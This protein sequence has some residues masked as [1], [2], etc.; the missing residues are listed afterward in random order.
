MRVH[1]ADNLQTALDAADYSTV[2]VLDAGG[3][4]TGNYQVKPKRW[5]DGWIYI[6]SSAF[7]LQES[8]AAPPPQTRVRPEDAEQMAKL[9]SPNMQPALAITTK[10]TAAATSHVRLVGLELTSTST[11]KADP[12][13]KPWPIN[14]QCP[15]LLALQGTDSITI[16]RCYIHGSDVV[17]VTHAVIA[18]QGASNIAVV[19][20]WISD[21]HI[22]GSDSQAFC[23]TSSPGPGKLV[24]NHFSASSEDVMFGGSGVN[25]PAPFNGYVPSDLEIRNNHFYKPE[26]WI[27]QTTGEKPYQWVVKNNLEF[28]SAARV[29]V[30]GN[31]ME[32]AWQ[33]GQ[34]GANLLIETNTAQSGPNAVTNDIRAE[35]NVFKNANWSVSVKGSDPSGPAV[36]ESRRVRI[37]FNMIQLRSIAS[38]A[39]YRPMGFSLGMGMFDYYIYANT[40]VCLDGRAPWASIYF[41]QVKPELVPDN[42]WIVDNVLQNPITGNGG[43]TGQKALDVYMPLPPP[44]NDRYV[45][46]IVS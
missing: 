33:S 21:A 10:G 29:I 7:Y 41:N 38:P 27:P 31:V 42:L 19:D 44:P 23:M 40:I 32:N 34:V 30:T 43:F 12:A 9:V 6:I 46:N 17:D 14:G 3:T 39:T 11:A 16:D 5:T 35:G 36:G 26:S 22:G 25:L 2:I 1:A 15:I 45:G 18:Y 4:Y 28:K 8:S 37:A 20:S 24:N 13:H